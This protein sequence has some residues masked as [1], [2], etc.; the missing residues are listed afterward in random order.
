MEEKMIKTYVPKV[1]PEVIA[2]QWAGDIESEQAIQRMGINCQSLPA[3]DKLKVFI[4]GG[5][6]LIPLWTYVV[7]YL[8]NGFITLIKQE[9]FEAH[10]VLKTDTKEN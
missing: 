1:M 6:M 10:Y 5:P 8:T 4:S 3:S 9:D 7:K 2:V